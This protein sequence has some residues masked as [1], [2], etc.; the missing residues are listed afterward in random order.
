VNRPNYE[1]GFDLN[2]FTWQRKQKHWKR[3]IHIV[4]PSCWLANCVKQSALMRDWPV[5]IVP[6]AI[7]TDQWQPIN[8]R[9]ARRLMR[10]PEDG[11]LILFGAMSGNNNP[12]KGFDLLAAALKGLQGKLF[13]LR[14]AIFGQLSPES[15]LD[16]GFPIHFR[17]HLYDDISLNL[18]YSAADLTVVPSRI[19]AFGQTASE[20]HACGTPVVAF[21]TSGLSDIVE[22][23]RTGYLAEPFDV[24][25]LAQGIC[26]VLDQK[27][28]GELSANART[29]AV[30]QFSYP[31]VA[32]QYQRVYSEV[33]GQ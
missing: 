28:S 33:A 19:E 5:F 29:R 13:D 3:P 14:L 16:L 6:N 32:E 12:I 9:V 15:P 26:W 23:L 31:V 10:L 27:E 20:A 4:T 21:E 8:Q 1:S 22:H 30:A 25:D 11:P 17:G 18:L 2:K 7:D 24:E